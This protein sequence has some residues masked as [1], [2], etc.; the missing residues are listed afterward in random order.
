MSEEEFKP[1][2]K[3]YLEENKEKRD[4]FQIEFNKEERDLF[5]DMQLFIC[6]TK[7]A[8]ALKQWAFYGWLAKS[9]PVKSERYFRDKLLINERNNKRLGID[10]KCELED[11]FQLKFGKIGWKM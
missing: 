5:L 1:F 9:N 6:Q 7:D 11:K 2:E 4:R 8:T 3:K 10:V